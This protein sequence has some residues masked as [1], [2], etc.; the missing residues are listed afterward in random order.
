[1]RHQQWMSVDKQYPQLAG[2]IVYY[3]QQVFIK[4]A[5]KI[6]IF[7]NVPCV[8][9]RTFVPNKKRLSAKIKSMK[10]MN[11]RTTA[12][13][14][15]ITK[16]VTIRAHD[17]TCSYRRFSTN[18]QHHSVSNLLTN[19][20]QTL[21]SISK[22][23]TSSKTSA[24]PL[25]FNNNKNQS[26]LLSNQSPNYLLKLFSTNRVFSKFIFSH[27][28]AAADVYSLFGW[29]VNRNFASDKTYRIV[30]SSRKGF[31]YCPLKQFHSDPLNMGWPSEY[32]QTEANKV[33][34]YG[35][36]KNV[37]TK[38][39]DSFHFHNLTEE[40]NFFFKLHNVDEQN[41][42]WE[43]CFPLAAESFSHVCAVVFFPFLP[44]VL[45]QGRCLR[46][47]LQNPSNPILQIWT[48]VTLTSGK[49]AGQTGFPHR[50]VMHE[51]Q[52]FTWFSKKTDLW[53]LIRKQSDL[54]DVMVVISSISLVNVMWWRNH[55][56]FHLSFK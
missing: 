41:R 7:T 9:F 51:T 43:E 2:R 35:E 38:I 20:Q 19:N 13:L 31:S 11:R 23:L 42:R 5:K 26:L 8:L 53:S 3:N 39:K 12:T 44:F 47:Q 6:Q 55:R 15:D 30:S 1:M 56:D 54:N 33:N 50:F 14:W 27:N 29:V 40:N 36:T 16:F 22:L 18:S 28:T 52:H 10:T 46:Y 32:D 34:I 17:V 45:L 21:I 37:L 25:Q 48:L 4:R 24:G 49:F